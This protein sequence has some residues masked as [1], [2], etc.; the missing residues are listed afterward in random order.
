M[1]ASAGPVDLGTITF[2][3]GVQ[4]I[5]T[6][7]LLEINTAAPGGGA[8]TVEPVGQTSFLFNRAVEG[9]ITG[10]QVSNLRTRLGMYFKGGRLYKVDQVVANGTVPAPQLVSALAT[11]QVCGDSGIASQPI[12]AN[13]NDFANPQGGWMFLRGPGADMLC[14]TADDN[15]WAV[16]LDM[17]A[18]DLA[19]TLPGEPQVDIL[20]ANGAYAGVVVRDGNQMRR[21]DAAI[22]NANTLLLTVDA[23]SYANLGRTFGSSLPGFWL[24]TEGGKLWGVN[25][26]TPAV[27]V[28]LATLDPGESVFPVIGS[29]GGSAFVGLS[30][31]TSARV[32]RVNE[33]LTNTTTVATLNQQLANMALTLTRLVL[34][35]Q[36]SPAQLLSLEKAGGPMTPLT[37]FGAGVI[38]G[39]LLTSGENVYLAQYQFGATGSSVSTLVVG[40]DGS[41]PVTLANT[42]IKRGVAPAVSPTVGL[43]NTY[44]VVLADGVT[45]LTSNAGATLRAVNGA[46]RSTL[47]TYG[48]LPASPDGVISGITTDPLQYGQSGLFLFSDFTTGIGNLYYFKSDAAG[49][50]RVTN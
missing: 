41:N 30:T 48:S 32:L 16:R 15:Y 46:T 39:A 21:T 23:A 8:V 35:T 10:S 6:Q 5:A 44:A 18:T 42:D 45:G 3:N 29:D 28:A 13:G 11:T 4:N 37:T 49:L 25:L 31:S 36:G 38:P 19:R 14:D 34:Q 33:S 2:A 26:A 47:V 43:N 20:A 9:T 12:Y 1:L 7:A 27:R 17:V 24:F 22:N 50:I 40:A